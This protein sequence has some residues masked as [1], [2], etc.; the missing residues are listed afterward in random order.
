MAGKANT[1]LKQLGR[2]TA[3]LQRPEEA[4]L[5]RVPNPHPDALYLVRFTAPEFTLLAAPQPR[6]SAPSGATLVDSDVQHGTEI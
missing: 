4:E 2:E 1:G 6:P 5:E 3:W